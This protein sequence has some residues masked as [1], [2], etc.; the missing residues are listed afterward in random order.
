MTLSQTNDSSTVGRVAAHT[1]PQLSQLSVGVVESQFY[2]FALHFSAPR[3]KRYYKLFNIELLLGVEQKQ[4]TERRGRWRKRVEERKREKSE[5]NRAKRKVLE[6]WNRFRYECGNRLLSLRLLHRC[7]SCSCTTVCTYWLDKFWIFF[8]FHCF[9]DSRRSNA[10]FCNIVATRTTWWWIL[11]QFSFRQCTAA[12]VYGVVT[13]K[14]KL[15]SKSIILTGVSLQRAKQFSLSIAASI[16]AMAPHPLNSNTAS[17]TKVSRF[18]HPEILQCKFT[19][20]RRKSCAIW[21]FLTTRSTNF[22]LLRA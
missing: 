16:Y 21:K 18:F 4:H 17:S 12:I 19:H 13:A 14:R 6:P 7:A 22:N 20:K 1:Y 9:F 2:S 5:M 11:M 3:A 15:H 10:P 8:S